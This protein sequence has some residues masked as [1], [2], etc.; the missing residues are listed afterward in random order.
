[1]STA[2]RFTLAEYDRMIAQAVFDP[3]REV[4][5]ELIHG[6][7]R[8]MT[9]PGPTHEEVI[10]LLNRWSCD[11]TSPEQVRVRIQNSIGIPALD[12]APQPDVAWVKAKS[13]RTGRPQPTDVLL[14]IEVSDSSLAYDRGEKAELYAEAGIADYWIVNLRDW[15]IEI[16]R[17]PHRNDYRQKQTY[18][19]HDAVS[20]L[21]RP[22]LALPVAQLFGPST[23]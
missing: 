3:D 15:C 20:P 23:E 6:E 16:Y 13:Y 21:V 9:P 10:D 19:L 2:F 7:I 12:S 4:R 5:T 22:E 14:L 18:T 11:N 1:M 17:D 8:E